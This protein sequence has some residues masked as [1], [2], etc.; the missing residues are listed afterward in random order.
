MPQVWLG[1]IYLKEEGG[2]EIILRALAHYRKRLK[3][4][5]K[6]PELKDA[7]MF[8][9]LVISEASKTGPQID[10]AISK[11]KNALECPETLSELQADIPLYEKALNCY[12]SDIKRAQNEKFY[13]DLL[14]GNDYIMADYS[15]IK[16]ALEKIKQFS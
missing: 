4:I 7:P 11:I 15:N 10:P 6:S 2:Y 1:G 8:A 13:S 3:S 16:T 5:G 12:E 9:T 14:S